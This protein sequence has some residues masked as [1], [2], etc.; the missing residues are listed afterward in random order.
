V[1]LT[2]IA[3]ATL[4]GKIKTL[5]RV[6][7]GPPLPEPGAHDLKLT[8]S[9]HLPPYADG[10]LPAPTDP[11]S[12]LLP[13]GFHPGWRFYLAF[14]T[15]CTITLAAALDATTISVALPIIAQAING[16]AI[17]AFWSGTSFLL[18]S[19]VFQ[20]IYASF[21]HIFGRKPLVRSHAVPVC[22][23]RTG[24]RGKREER[25]RDRERRGLT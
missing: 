13:P 20:P 19:T 18:T 4:L 14:T 10:A 11:V 24:K 7:T 2:Q 1:N 5:E 3:M 16:T 22:F 9:P 12:S 23:F 8:A 6:L 25:G 21:S 15:L 17:E